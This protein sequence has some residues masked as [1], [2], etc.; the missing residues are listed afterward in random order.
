MSTTHK[1]AVVTRRWA[2][3]RQCTVCGKETHD[4]K[5]AKAHYFAEHIREPE[6]TQPEVGRVETLSKKATKEASCRDGA[7]LLRCLD[8]ILEMNR[9]NIMANA[10][11]PTF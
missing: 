2:C 3:I 1:F 8:K 11:P 10:G 5:A 9:N 6:V 7:L 4:D